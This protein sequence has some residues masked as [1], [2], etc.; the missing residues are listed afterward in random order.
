MANDLYM[1]TDAESAALTRTELAMI[2][3]MEAF[4]RWSFFVNKAVSN[5][6][7]NHSDV[8]LLHSIRMRGGAQNLSELLLFLN[9]N[10][11]STIQYSLRKLEQNGL[12]ERIVGNSKREAGYTLTQA[13]LDSTEAYSKV[14]D[15]VLV[16]LIAEI[17][18]FVPALEDAAAAMERLTGLY[19]QSTQSVL[20]R[21]ILDPNLVQ[22]VRTPRE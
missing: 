16:N 17:N 20:N 10:D 6:V 9:R 19:D 12:V 3:A 2:R 13:G 5:N 14:R 15:E 8:S 7:L 21:R 4:A 22:G 11:V 1:T 18:N